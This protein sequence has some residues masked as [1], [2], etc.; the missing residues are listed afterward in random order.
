MRA[1][2]FVATN[3]AQASRAFYQEVLGFRLVADEAFA[4][5]FDADGIELRVQKVEQFSPQPFTVLGW[6]VEDIAAKV[7]ELAGKGARFE[8]FAWLE[9]KQNGIWV[10]ENGDQVAWFKDPTDNLLSLTQF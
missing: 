10:A 4:L 7:A 9:Q 3:Q 8:R 1:M 5:V 2:M 6:Q